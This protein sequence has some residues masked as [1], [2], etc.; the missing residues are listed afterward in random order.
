M[1]R[2]HFKYLTLLILAM[3]F[4]APGIMAYLFYQHPTWLGSAKTNRG[5]LLASPIQLE[6][7]NGNP[8][9]KLV[10]WKPEGC[11]KTCLNQLNSIGRVRLALGRKLYQVDEWLLLDHANKLE[12]SELRPIFKEQDIHVTTIKKLE[13]AKLAELPK[14]ETIFIVNPDNFI[15]LT[16]KEGGNPDD[17]YKDM[18][19]LLNTSELKGA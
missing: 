10:Y 12:A 2:Q 13:A 7:F 19:L 15:V 14:K 18:K 4:A 11:D 9:W 6:V 1:Q 3:T 5:R 8:K 16:Y 17:I